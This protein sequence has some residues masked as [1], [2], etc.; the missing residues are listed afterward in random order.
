MI[1]ARKMRLQHN[2]L[3]NQE[4]LKHKS[5]INQFNNKKLLNKK[6]NKKN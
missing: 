2:F 4:K 5:L 3:Y 6:R 1:K